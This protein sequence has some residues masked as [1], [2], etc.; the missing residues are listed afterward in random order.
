[1][2]LAG[3][4]SGR[5]TCSTMIVST[6]YVK[7][8]IAEVANKEVNAWRLSGVL[9][10]VPLATTG[11][12]DNGRPRTAAVRSEADGPVTRSHRPR[13]SGSW[14]DY[15]A[16]LVVFILDMKGRVGRLTNTQWK[17]SH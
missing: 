5:S 13:A 8:A 1:M 6:A 9:G 12:A 15:C 11:P 7:Q 3:A 10:G 2:W 16:V 17:G 4:Y 14:P